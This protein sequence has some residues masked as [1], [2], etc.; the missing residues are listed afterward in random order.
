[1][2]AMITQKASSRLPT[3]A[4]M[5]LLPRRRRMSGFSYTCLRNL[6]H[7][8]S[9]G[10]SSNSLGPYRA[11]RAATEDWGRPCVACD[12]KSAMVS[13]LYQLAAWRIRPK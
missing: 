5:K 2:T 7:S 9:V 4:L 1:M 3:S 12:A 10:G 13:C 6:S 11:K 8:G